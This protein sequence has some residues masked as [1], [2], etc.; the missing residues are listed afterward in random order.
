[1]LTVSIAPPLIESPV[2]E[3]FQPESGYV[4][5]YIVSNMIRVYQKKDQRKRKIQLYCCLK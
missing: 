4:E 2:T 3:N 1:M 5:L